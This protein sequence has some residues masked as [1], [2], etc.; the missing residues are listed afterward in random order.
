MDSEGALSEIPSKHLQSLADLFVQHNIHTR[1]GL[2]LV[3]RHT[4]LA[5][6]H[7]M[8]N[9]KITSP[10]GYWSKP[11]SFQDVNLAEV[12]GH[13]FQLIGEDRFVAYEVTEGKLSDFS[14]ISAD[15]FRELA[16]YLRDNALDQSLGLEVLGDTEDMIEMDFGDC[17][18]VMLQDEDCHHGKPFR[19]TGWKF[20]YDKGI[21]S[22]KGNTVHAATNIGPH[23]VFVDGKLCPDLPALK[24]LLGEFKVIE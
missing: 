15:F 18:T 6:G 24:S 19:T 20:T 8:L 16:L 13:I 21:I 2:H 22:Y 3:H 9:H 17:G 10:S 11:T 12:H 23:K 5:A 4:E 14:D 1:F 7:V